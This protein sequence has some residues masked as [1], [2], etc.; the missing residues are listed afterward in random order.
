MIDQLDWASKETGYFSNAWFRPNKLG[1]GKL[2]DERGKPVTSSGVV[3]DIVN[4]KRIEEK[5]FS[6]IKEYKEF[7]KGG[8][9]ANPG[10]VLGMSKEYANAVSK[11]M[12]V[13]LA[14]FV[15]VFE[16]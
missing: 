10:I 5:W 2:R 14:K 9:K 12:E 4:Y 15:E 8:M 6:A 7:L 1:Y 3:I 11:A 16:K 13:A